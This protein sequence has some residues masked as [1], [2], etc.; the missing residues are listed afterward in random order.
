V[1][2]LLVQLRLK[3]GTRN[4]LSTIFK[5]EFGADD[6]AVKFIEYCDKIG[7]EVSVTATN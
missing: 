4:K 5:N 7:V 3:H 1:Q 2:R 6:G